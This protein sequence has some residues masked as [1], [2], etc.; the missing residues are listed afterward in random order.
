MHWTLFAQPGWTVSTCATSRCKL[1]GGGDYV[2]LVSPDAKDVTVIVETFLHSASQCIR[3][4]PPDWKVVPS[5]IV[6]VALP[7]SITEGRD[8]MRVLD[9]WRS[10][11]GWRYPADD[12]SFMVKQ[13]PVPV[14]ETG[15]VTFI[16]EVNCYYT[17]TTIKGVTKPLLPSA[18]AADPRPAFFPLPFT[19]DFEGA[20]A[21][22][23]APFFG[24]QEG[25]W[26][27]VH[28]GGGRSGKASQQ[29]LGLK[30]W[31]ILEPQCND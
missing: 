22:G 12:D 5:Q 23:E 18:V 17:L 31:P 10:C 15:Q 16:A 24:D 26:E 19:E 9:L 11:T 1:S 25:K 21:G 2:L 4:D 29:Q 7:A 13:A 30:P 27:T 6:T 3:Q 14:D 20:T 28:A 8:A